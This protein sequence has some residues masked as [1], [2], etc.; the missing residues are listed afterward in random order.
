MKIYSIPILLNGG[1]PDQLVWLGHAS[2]VYTLASAYSL[3]RLS[4]VLATDLD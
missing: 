2:G 1:E 4:G 3:L